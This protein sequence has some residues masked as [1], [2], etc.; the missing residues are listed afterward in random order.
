MSELF[1][2]LSAVND[3]NHI[4]VGRFLSDEAIRD[5]I[6]SEKS[7]NPVFRTTS[8]I[9]LQIATKQNP[10]RV[11]L[12]RTIIESVYRQLNDKCNA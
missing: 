2:T 7:C 8:E 4:I 1:G 12:I 6:L 9:I 11:E 3:T 5:A 10:P